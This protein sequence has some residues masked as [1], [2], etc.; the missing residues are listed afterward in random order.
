MGN[1][2]YRRRVL[3][4]GVA[5]RAITLAGAGI[6]VIG[7]AAPVAARGVADPAIANAVDR[8]G[9]NSSAGIEGGALQPVPQQSQGVSDQ[10]NA[11]ADQ[12]D[13]VI[14]VTGSRIRRRELVGLEPATSL[15]QAYLQ[16][17]NLTNVADALNELP[18]FRG[19]VT[20]SG[21]QA[22]YGNGV[23]FI[24]TF[25]L[26]S[27][28]TL[29]LINGRRSVSSNV[30][31]QFGP[32]GPG[33]QVDL[34]IIPT[35]AIER[36]ESLSVGG[37]PVYGSDAISG[38][39][40]V[41]MRRRF[42][43]ARFSATS[44]IS[45]QGDAF[46]YNFSGLVGSD[47]AEGRG[48]VMVAASFDRL[49]GLRGIDRAFIR[50]NLGSLNNCSGTAAPGN[51]G[52]VNPNIP[53][54][55]GAT[56]GVP[57]RILFRNLTSPFLSSGG[58]IINGDTGG[59]TGLQFDAAGRIV[60]VTSG[61]RLTGFFQ[62]GG[63][64]Y[65]TSDQTQITS[66]LQ[67]F[68]TY[69]TASYKL[70]DAAEVFTEV[71]YYKGRAEQLGNSPTFNTFVF[72]PD[73]SG[74][75]TFDTATV[76]FLNAAD[77]TL[78]LSRGITS[79]NLS[80][81]NEDLFDQSAISETELKRG[82]IGLRG[83]FKAIGRQLNYEASFNYGTNQIQNFS[84]QINQQR[85]IN[86]VSVT[87]GAS[88]PV[89]SV[90]PT[91]P[92]APD[93][94]VQ[95]IADAR[96]V[97]LN[98]F[99]VR[100]ASAAALAYISENTVDTARLDQWVFNANIGGDLID[101]WAGSIGF[102]LGYEHR[103]EK[104]AFTPDSFTQ[105]G[106]GRGSAVAP[107]AGQ[108]NVDE[109]FGEILVP[110]IS[111]DNNIPVITS[112]EVFG[113][114]R[115]VNNTV[116]G[117]FTSW[118]AGGRIGL[119][120]TL[121][122]RG[123]FTRS[124]RAPAITE[125]FLPQSPTQ[126]RPLDLCTAANRNAGPVPAMR[127]ANCQAFLQATGNDPASYVLLASQASVAGLNGGNPQLANEQ[128][129]SYTFGTIFQPSFVRG[130]TITA[131]YVNIK[132]KGPIE[133]LDT[134]Q[135]SQGCFDN[136]N[137]DKSN[138]RSGN[139][140]CRQLGFAANGQ[141]PN[142]PTN[143]AVR[144]GYVNGQQVR[145]EGITGV[146]DYQTRLDGLNIPGTLNLGA[147][148]L[149]VMRRVNDITGVAPRRSDGLISNSDPRI[150]GQARASYANDS[151][152]IAAFA[153]IVGRQIVSL[154]NRGPSP[155]D[156]REFDHFDPYATINMNVFFLTSDDS[157]FNISVTNLFNRQGQE[158]YGILIPLSINDQIGRR[159]SVSFVKNF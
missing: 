150:S 122:F 59:R 40:N 131:D 32:G 55:N 21:A 129:D 39:L 106:G 25:G 66:N 3:G 49:N 98:L 20:P 41:I 115:Y 52:R 9:V 11:S 139:E 159:F 145:F 155:N 84:R 63:N 142:S 56:D 78:L 103:N 64:T 33:V 10:E 94:P 141:I 110:L 101:L 137:F 22:S 31:S 77:R 134:D 149:Y 81:S 69:A 7:M 72:D 82:V 36:T 154:Q 74:G 2:I 38:V 114:G 96:C 83:D 68:S 15:D 112:A 27:N 24:N 144:S 35:L 135:L 48:N 95:P 107:T 119:F 12:D 123:N 42:D 132:I 28:R 97:P 147:D 130:L 6:S 71:L 1:K 44:G 29:T 153:N 156:T 111:R 87:Q 67:R 125:L 19:S 90:T 138:P 136:V 51:D 58:V 124:F 23:N 85:F 45:E 70:A 146:L 47:F 100:Q 89:C 121:Q 5:I 99:G 73:T 13:G 113:R 88:G 93:Q 43:G 133:S 46:N 8:G 118:A 61:T 17:R 128:A 126:V 140:F 4:R 18:Q 86:A 108:F 14:T 75:L 91:V 34:N 120:D 148:V 60:P 26:G 16:N 116:N 92:V 50:Q 57:G 30:P 80:R 109:V 127:A 143:P 62:S 158:Y 53:C 152:G 105:F 117:E 76:P 151:W 54:N 79:L 65:Q 102:N 104:A 37:A 157:R